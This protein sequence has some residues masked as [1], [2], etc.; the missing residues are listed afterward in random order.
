MSYKLTSSGKVYLKVLTILNTSSKLSTDQYVEK[1]ILEACLATKLDQKY[2][3]SF[4][5]RGYLEEIV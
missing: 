5:K 4:L 1:V 2:I 3:D